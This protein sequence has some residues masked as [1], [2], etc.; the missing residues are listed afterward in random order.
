[1]PAEVGM[2]S[3]HQINRRDSLV[4]AASVCFTGTWGFGTL[5]LWAKN[6]YRSKMFAK[7][8]ALLKD[9]RNPLRLQ[10]SWEAVNQRRQRS[11]QHPQVERRVQAVGVEVAGDHI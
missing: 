3:R 7:L 2:P 11:S 8:F 9:S 4:S 10:S 6:F 1:M 5:L